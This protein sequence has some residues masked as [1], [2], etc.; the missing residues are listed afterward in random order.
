[1]TS[2]WRLGHQSDI[3]NHAPPTV[4][5]HFWIKRLLYYIQ[6]VY[7]RKNKPCPLFSSF[8]IPYF[9][10]HNTKVKNG[11]KLHTNFNKLTS[12]TN[13]PLAVAGLWTISIKSCQIC[14]IFWPRTGHIISNKTL[15]YTAYRCVL[16]INLINW[17]YQQLV[18][19]WNKIVAF[20]KL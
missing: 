2:V 11:R 8:H 14:I 6:S 9:L 7:S 12:Q 3:L 5:V 4:S 20:W 17:Q 18:F 13:W 19:P 15:E 16:A 10:H 1:M